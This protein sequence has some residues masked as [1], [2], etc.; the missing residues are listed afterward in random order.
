MRPKVRHGVW[1]VAVVLVLVAA[2]GA[3]TP[4]VFGAWDCE[5]VV[6][7]EISCAFCFYP[8]VLDG[9]VCKLLEGWCSDGWHR[10]GWYCW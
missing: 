9:Q 8:F 6:A 3:P 2:L 4:R 5:R 7:G 10:R 1:V